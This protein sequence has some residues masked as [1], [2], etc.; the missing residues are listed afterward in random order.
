M[1][2]SSEP[3]T[4]RGVSGTRW[5]LSVL[6]VTIAAVLAVVAVAA[7]GSAGSADECDWYEA[8]G[9][10]GLTFFHM[11]ATGIAL[12]VV[13]LLPLWSI[14]IRR[15]LQ[16]AGWWFVGIALMAGFAY[17]YVWSYRDVMYCSGSL[18]DFWPAWLPLPR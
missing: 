14:P 7:Q 10:F 4:G 12:T 13:G 18:P 15:M 17:V 1:H 6:T 9:R 2:S 11:P 3:P 8:G 16:L 5:G